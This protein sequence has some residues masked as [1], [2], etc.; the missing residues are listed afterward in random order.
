MGCCK[1]CLKKESNGDPDECSPLLNGSK[2]SAVNVSQPNLLI[3]NENYTNGRLSLPCSLKT[4]CDEQAILTGI[5][6]NLNKKVID[7]TAIDSKISSGEYMDRMEH[8]KQKIAMLPKTRHAYNFPQ[9]LSV[10]S[11]PLS[12]LNA[13][14]QPYHEV[15]LIKKFSEDIN[16]AF[17]VVRIKRS[18]PLISMQQSR[19][20]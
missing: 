3:T 11:N 19:R 1:S 20:R 13:P 14:L 12:V 9:L 16:N 15:E 5:V 2:S 4:K 17:G 7:I 8:Y 6:N 18:Q 10:A